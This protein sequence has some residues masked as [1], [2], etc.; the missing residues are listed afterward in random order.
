MHV[1]LC[2]PVL[3]CVHIF[4]RTST[5]VPLAPRRSRVRFG[6]IRP[7]CPTESGRPACTAAKEARDVR[8]E[9]IW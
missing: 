3:L 5:T 6:H 7:L 8:F 2:L 4:F 9:I 1:T